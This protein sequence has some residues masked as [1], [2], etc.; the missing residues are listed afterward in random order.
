VQTGL[1]GRVEGPAVPGMDDG[2]SGV[3]AVAGDAVGRVTV[4]AVAGDD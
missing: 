3:A 2:G 4:R 1:A